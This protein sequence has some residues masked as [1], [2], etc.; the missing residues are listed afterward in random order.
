MKAVGFTGN[1]PEFIGLMLPLS[2][3]CLWSSAPFSPITSTGGLP[4][5]LPS[6]SLA[7]TFST[8]A[9]NPVSSYRSLVVMHITDRD[10]DES[11]SSA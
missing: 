10:G 6:W 1:T 11:Y 4:M 9:H 3:W 5:V 2:C 8:R 7:S